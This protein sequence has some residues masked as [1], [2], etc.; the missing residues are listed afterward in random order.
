MQRSLGAYR[1]KPRQEPKEPKELKPKPEDRLGPFNGCRSSQGGFVPNPGKRKEATEPVATHTHMFL[2]GTLFGVVLKDSQKDAAIFGSRMTG[3]AGE[4]I[5]CVAG[6]FH[7][8]RGGNAVEGRPCG[9]VVV[10]CLVA[11]VCHCRLRIG[12]RDPRSLCMV[13]CYRA[14]VSGPDPDSVMCCDLRMLD[15]SLSQRV[16]CT[17]VLWVHTPTYFRGP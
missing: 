2:E 7:G 10:V 15:L 4:C 9:W 16:T 13:P 12:I 3:S 6:V 11:V 17:I 14:P 5:L 1:S 8:W